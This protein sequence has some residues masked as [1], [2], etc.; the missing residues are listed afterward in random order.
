[1]KLKD[2]ITEGNKEKKAMDYN[3]GVHA[4]NSAFTE[5]SSLYMRA[6]GMMIQNKK[7]VDPKYKKS[8]D[9]IATAYE[10]MGS[11]INKHLEEINK[12]K[13]LKK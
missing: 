1:M 9:V 4:L 6:L 11:S 2:Y 10:R 7:Y 12:P 3:N 13:E 8:R 5:F